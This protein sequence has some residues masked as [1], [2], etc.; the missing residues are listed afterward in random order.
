VKV[1]RVAWT[2]LRAAQPPAAEASATTRESHRNAYSMVVDRWRWLDVLTT[3]AQISRATFVEQ[4]KFRPFSGVEGSESGFGILRDRALFGRSD[5]VARDAA[6][7][8]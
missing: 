5:A 7:Q 8:N 6:S 4:R 3:D 2:T 1:E